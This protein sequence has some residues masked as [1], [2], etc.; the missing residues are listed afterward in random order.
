[1]SRIAWIESNTEIKVNRAHSD[2]EK[3]IIVAQA[4]SQRTGIGAATMRAQSLPPNAL[5]ER[6]NRTL[7]NKVRVML[8]TAKIDRSKLQ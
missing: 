6:I 3:E 4:R 7:L 2:S 5:S 8:K 1:M